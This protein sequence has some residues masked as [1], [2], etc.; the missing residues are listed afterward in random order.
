VKINSPKPAESKTTKASDAVKV[1]IEA[2][3]LC[4][5]FTA[6][7]IRGVKIQPSPKWFERPAWKPPA[8]PASTTSWIFP[9]T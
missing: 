8:P 1:K 5:R 9:T 4:G 7:V 6:R 2:Q 3:D